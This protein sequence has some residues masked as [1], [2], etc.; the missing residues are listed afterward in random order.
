M[1]V[2][3]ALRGHCL[4]GTD[5]Y[6]TNEQLVHPDG[7]I[8]PVGEV[9]GYYVVMRDYFER[10]RLPIMHTETNMREPDAVAW[11]WKTWVNIQQLR[12]DGIPV[13][14]MTWYS[15]T[16]QVDWDTA[17]REQNGNVNPLGLYDLDRNIRNVGKAYKQ[18]IQDWRDVLPAQSLCLSVPIVPPSQSSRLYAL[19]QREE[20]AARREKQPTEASTPEMG[21]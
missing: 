12:R 10:Y 6:R 14:G 13:C 3:P 5:Y 4:L 21:P 8:H 19:E 7:H 9:F 16:D 11:M 2:G 15:L 20:A 18:L 17:L 1:E